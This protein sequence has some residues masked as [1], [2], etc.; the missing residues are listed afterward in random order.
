VGCDFRVILCDF[1]FFAQLEE[2]STGGEGEVVV[3]GWDEGY[4]MLLVMA[5]RAGSLTVSLRR[6][7]S[8]VE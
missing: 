6:G 8:R 4:L 5:L 1:W 3:S 2:V 7:S